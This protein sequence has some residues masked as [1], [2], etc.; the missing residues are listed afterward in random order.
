MLFLAFLFSCSGWKS[1]NHTD[2]AA[3]VGLGQ[4]QGLLLKKKATGLLQVV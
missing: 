1:P 2:L 3:E 4:G